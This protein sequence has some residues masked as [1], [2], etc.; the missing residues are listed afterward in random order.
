MKTIQVAT[1]YVLVLIVM[2]FCSTSCTEKKTKTINNSEKSQPNIILIMADDLGYGELSCYGST[3]I[4]TPNIDQLAAEGVKLTDFHSNGP[5]CSPTRAALMTGKYQQRTG[6]E[7]VITAKSHREVGLSLDETTIAELLKAEGYFCGMYG[8][9][10]LGYAEAFNP[11]YQGFDEFT[12]FVG[13]NIDY[14]SHVDQEG[15]L[16]WWKN[17]VIDNEEGYTTDLITKHGVEFIKKYNSNKTG[18]PF[19]LYLS[20]EAPHYPIQGRNDAPV[21]EVGNK[22]YIRK[23]LNDS[24]QSIYIS[25]IETMDEGVGEIVNAVKEEGLF[26]N[27]IIVFC[28]DNGAVG[29]RGDNGVLR[30]SKASVYEGGHRVPAII[31]YSGKIKPGIVNN[32]PVMSMDFLPTFVEFANEKTT[33][34]NIDGVSIKN[35]LLQNEAIAERDLFWK[36]RGRIAVRSGKWKLVTLYLAEEGERINHLFNLETDLS[37]KYNVAKDHPELV[38][39][40]LDKIEK[41]QKDVYKGVDMVAE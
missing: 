18:K 38:S 4:S 40:L 14:H 1:K 16:D 17:K 7:G 41:W 34:N 11:T 21:R 23:V 32:T 30:D 28:S 22:K 10:H 8:K 37:E 39:E 13:G 35:M 9:W 6:V 33:V 26:E 31:T 2:V 27:T 12:G 15:Y 5:L 36:F 29:K 25:M 19:F 20:Q 3:K 24:I